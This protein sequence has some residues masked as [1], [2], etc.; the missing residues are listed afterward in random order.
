VRGVCQ[1]C[2]FAFV[3]VVA[4]VFFFCGEFWQGCIAPSFTGE[5]GWRC[6]FLLLFSAEI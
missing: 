4:F 5:R 3:V 2:G 1:D 6:F